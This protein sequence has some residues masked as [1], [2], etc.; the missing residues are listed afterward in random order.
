MGECKVR[1]NNFVGGRMQDQKV[2]WD[3]AVNVKA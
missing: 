1:T 2:R 3:H